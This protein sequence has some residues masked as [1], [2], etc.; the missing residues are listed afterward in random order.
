MRKEIL[1]RRF[2][3]TTLILITLVLFGAMVY[4]FLEGWSY[5]NSLYFTII[6]ITTIGYG[7]MY[8][9]TTLG[10]VFTMIFPFVGIGMG[11]YFLTEVGKYII[12]TSIHTLHQSLEFTHITP[13]RDGPGR[14]RNVGRPKKK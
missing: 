13:H 14:P 11:F 3:V 10:K 1:Y 12:H 7:D 5:F 8:P 9:I 6:T 4:S 2:F